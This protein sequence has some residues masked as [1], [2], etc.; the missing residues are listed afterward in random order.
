MIRT[1]V[2]TMLLVLAAT[3]QTRL[4]QANTAASLPLSLAISGEVTNPAGSA[5]ANGGSAQ[6]SGGRLDADV[7]K[8]VLRAGTPDEERFIDYVVA[9]VNKG[10]LPLDLVHS[11]FLW[12]KKKPTNKKFFYFKRALMLRA[13]D[14]GIKL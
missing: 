7:M 8:V 10:T 13:A 4:V 5:A 1:A 2:L 12:A 11:T 9:R 6:S 14:R 3:L